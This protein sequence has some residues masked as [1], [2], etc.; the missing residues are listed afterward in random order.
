[1]GM[2]NLPP[3]LKKKKNNQNNPPKNQ[4]KNNKGQALQAAIW[5]LLRDYLKKR[6]IL[7]KIEDQRSK[8]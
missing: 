4:S 2:T 3:K 7:G 5:N 8:V 6:E 1:M